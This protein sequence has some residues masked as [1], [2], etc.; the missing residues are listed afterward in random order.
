[1]GSLIENP[2]V[3]A[4]MTARENLEVIRR[5]FGITNKQAVDDMLAFVGLADTNKKKV[6]NFYWDWLKS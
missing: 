6:K 1:M 2:G 5:N 3:Y 4:N